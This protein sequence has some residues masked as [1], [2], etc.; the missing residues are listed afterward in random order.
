MIIAKK[1]I[2]HL[3]FPK[4][5]STFIQ[6]F[7]KYLS[8]ICSEKNIKYPIS[9]FSLS[10]DAGNLMPF[11][12]S[13]ILKSDYVILDDLLNLNAS[14]KKIEN[15]PVD[16][17]VLSSEEGVYLD[18]QSLKVFLNELKK[19]SDEIVVFLVKRS[20]GF[21]ESLYGQGVK[22]N[23]YYK[24]LNN[25][26]LEFNEE[27]FTKKVSLLSNEVRLIA[28][29]N[30]LEINYSK[31]GLG[32]DICKIIGVS[33]KFFVDFNE[34]Y[35]NINVSINPLDL[36]IQR[37]LNFFSL[38]IYVGELSH[39][40][41]DIAVD[42]I[43]SDCINNMKLL[44]QSD[45]ELEKF[46]LIMAALISTVSTKKSDNEVLHRFACTMAPLLDKYLKL[47]VVKN[48]TYL[49]PFTYLMLNPDIALVGLDPLE[50]YENY[51]I[52]EHRRINL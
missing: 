34:K 27:S 4:A 42:P 32:K 37:I 14:N 28:D 5:G 40:I 19:Y 49:N 52:H 30:F 29:L 16:C 50:H 36:E 21:V 1:I 2:V 46:I 25:F 44:I 12:N 9:R 48:G 35:N 41:S 23:G 10:E 13:F 38:N 45:V 39:Q 51:G 31:D 3:G 11:F 20:S 33:D 17:L 6:Q 15:S 18:P 47:S 43:L 22:M 8:E 24:S 26:I 7:S